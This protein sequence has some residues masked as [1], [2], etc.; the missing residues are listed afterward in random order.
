MKIVHASDWHGRLIELPEAD[1]YVFTGDMLPN[2]PVTERDYGLRLWQIVPEVER[3][4][5]AEWLADRKHPHRG[6]LASPEAPVICVRGN[7]DFIDA[8]DLFHGADVTEFVDNEDCTVLGRRFTGHRGI[9][10]INGTWSDEVHRPDLIDMMKRMRRADVYV[11][12]YPPWGVLDSFGTP[13]AEGHYGLEEMA[14]RLISLSEPPADRPLELDAVR[15]LHLFGHIHEHGGV[16]R[17]EA[18]V[19][20]SNAATTFNVIDL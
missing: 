6:M 15:A 11:T 9:P 1:V 16:T 7:H 18:N 17:Q 8:A 14:Y 19:L 20:F 2:F 5:Q 4:K 12:H 13:G 10:W 3:A